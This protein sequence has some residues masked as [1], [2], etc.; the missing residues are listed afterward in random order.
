[1]PEPRI[2]RLR[3]PVNYGLR[4]LKESQFNVSVD[5]GDDSYIYNG[6]T[7]ALLRCS[8]QEYQGVQHI[9]QSGAEEDT[10]QTLIDY[11]LKGGMLVP[12]HFDELAPLRQLYAVSRNNTSSFALTIVTSLWCNFECPYCFEEK[13]P[14]IMHSGVQKELL[15]ILDDRLPSISKFNVTWFGGEPLMGKAALL[16]LSDAFI[17]WCTNRKVSYRS[18]ISTN[19]Y[20]LD[21][22]TCSQLRDRL[23]R[24]V[25]IGGLDGPPHVHDRMRPRVGGGS[26]FWGI[27][28]NLKHAVNY[29]AVSLRVN[30]D[31]S[32]QYT[33]EE[34]LRILADEGL[35]G[36]LS[37]YPAPIVSV[38]NPGSGA[39][40]GRYGGCCL[41]K[42]QFAHVELAFYEL[43][44]R[45][46]FSKPKLPRPV[47]APCTAVRK[48]E[49]IVGSS[50]ELYKCWD[51]VGNN[52]DVIGHIR[53]YKNLNG[54]L[55]KWIT[56]D[57]FADGE[58]QKCIALPVCMGGCAHHAMDLRLRE[59]RCSTFRYT[60]AAQISSYVDSIQT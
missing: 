26:S 55:Q 45:Y 14:S 32:N 28:K 53:D 41:A 54:R 29:F 58:C 37:I 19:G 3:Q 42:Q 17:A 36:K 39:P 48:N 59:S 46:G 21:E 13:Y 44:R 22:N 57:P 50:G 23:V 47:G 2:V 27:V 8:S 16:D 10:P 34:M 1:M 9:L 31:E 33:I 43:A 40:S 15:N 11:M 5:S 7:G 52:N 24:S 20:L 38:V 60:Y 18:N 35:S 4:G 51:S 12:V 30:L 6:V 49:L 25:Q 56:Y